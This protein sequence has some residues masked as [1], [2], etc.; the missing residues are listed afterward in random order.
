MAKKS[1]SKKTTAKKPSAKKTTAKK[2]VARAA[3]KKTISKKATVK[4]AEIKKTAGKKPALKKES[5]KKTAGKKPSIKNAVKKPALN[6]KEKK[7]ASQK[8]AVKKAKSIKIAAK[9]PSI[10]KTAAK[11]PAVK[12]QVIKKTTAK[13]PVDKKQVVKKTA[14]KK[15][16]VKKTADKK[17]ADKKQAVKKT[18]AKKI[19][20][21]KINWVSAEDFCGD[22]KVKR[23]VGISSEP[24]A[25]LT[26]EEL[27]ELYCQ[28]SK[29][30]EI[31]EL[32][33]KVLQKEETKKSPVWFER[34]S[35]SLCYLGK[36]KEAVKVNI[37]R[38]ALFPKDRDAWDV[39]AIGHAVLGDYNSAACAL[40]EAEEKMNWDVS[41]NETGINEKPS[42]KAEF[43]NSGKEEKPASFSGN[44]WR[45]Y[46]MSAV[47]PKILNEAPQCAAG[48]YVLA[49]FYGD[50]LRNYSGAAE[51][52]K[53]A[54]A[55]KPDWKQALAYQAKILSFQA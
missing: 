6:K 10:K 17:P 38:T 49:K 12:K 7:T 19:T 28:Q 18:V 20:V 31:L 2:P 16:I 27:A 1:I 51:A 47:Y 15:Q 32:C 33:K 22:I 48:W 55:L 53:K 43:N 45:R 44:D 14:A 42:V 36:W 35:D 52:I 29:H 25:M 23:A 8:P 9:K 40:K 11:K 26:N 13:K 3:V 41:F 30:E 39:L 46:A 4:K 37:K 54:V 5:A 34:Q 24:A 50:D 21:K